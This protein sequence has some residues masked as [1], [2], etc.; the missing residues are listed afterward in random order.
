MITQLFSFFQEHE[1]RKISVFA[2]A[3][4]AAGPVYAEAL[5]K[6]PPSSISLPGGK[7]VRLIRPV[8]AGLDE[9]GGPVWAEAASVA[10]V[11]PHVVAMASWMGANGSSRILCLDWYDLEQRAYAPRTLLICPAEGPMKGRRVPVVYS[12]EEMEWQPVKAGT[13]GERLFRIAEREAQR[14]IPEE[15]KNAAKKTG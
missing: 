10:P 1:I 7:S 5:P 15:E 14:R 2:A 4:F 12:E 3:L 8:S 13:L 9:E 11:R 6:A